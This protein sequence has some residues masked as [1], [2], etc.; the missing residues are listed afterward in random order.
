MLKILLLTPQLPY[1]PRQ[2][3]SL[4]NFNIIQGLSGQYELTLLSYLEPG[5]TADPHKI[6]PLLRLCAAVHTVPLTL[7]PGW[8][9]LGQMLF[10]RQ[11]D[12]AHRLNR[13]EF[14]VAL[15]QLLATQRFDIVQIEGIELGPF[16]RIV[17]E[18]SPDSKIIFD[19][20]NA[21]AELQRRAFLT[22]LGTPRRWPAAFYSW[23]QARRL[24]R[25]ER[26]ACQMADGVTAVS[27]LDAKLLQEL[28]PGLDVT[29]IPNCI[30]VEQYSQPVE[31]PIPFDLVFIGKMDYRPN[32]DAML[33]FAQEIWPIIIERRPETTLAIVG[34]RPHARLAPLR[35]LPNVAI[36]GQVESVR[37][38]LDGA[39]VFIMP[40]RLG[41]GTRLKLIEA[42]AAGKA[43]VATPIGAEG[44][45]LYNNQEALLAMEPA[46]FAHN[47][48][49]LLGQP[50]ERERLGQNARQF[51]VQY[52]WRVVI[53]QF[54]QVYN[55]AVGKRQRAIAL[56][57]E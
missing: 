37:P 14:A 22:D 9:R 45:P 17:K 13:P 16:I 18:V 34:Q 39:A 31:N 51:A 29:A 46:D 8:R 20:H 6:E 36:T 21:E 4:R 55:A 19:D 53:P 23:V 25:F 10:S 30:D 57:N 5:Q 50:T 12:M 24:R 26:W 52:D 41:S 2:G 56:M 38:Y 44:F 11:P 28:V 40:F 49:H 54:A 1:P 48:L 33:W 7:R 32:I 35:A 15:R 43:I 47:V 27:A 42:M 3:A